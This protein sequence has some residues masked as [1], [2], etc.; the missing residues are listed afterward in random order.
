VRLDIFEEM[1]FISF[2]LK[3][4]NRLD[5]IHNCLGLHANA[6]LHPLWIHY[7]SEFKNYS[8][9]TLGFVAFTIVEACRAI[10]L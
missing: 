4:K 2:E 1:V 6:Q 7:F 5:M 9:F 8:K 10:F 3:T